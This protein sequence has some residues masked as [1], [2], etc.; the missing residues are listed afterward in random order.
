MKIIQI[1]D[2]HLVPKGRSLF[3]ND[4]GVRLEACIADIAANHADADLCVITGDLAH[5]GE[6]GAYIRL[7]EALEALPVPVRLVIGNHDARDEFLQVFPEE[8]TDADGFVQS[9]IDTDAGRLLVLD[10]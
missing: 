6:H 2:L 4:P 3:E 1:T 5:H 10:T 8:P 7:R 9:F